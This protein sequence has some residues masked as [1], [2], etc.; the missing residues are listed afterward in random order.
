MLNARRLLLHCI[1]IGRKIVLPEVL[2]KV[3]VAYCHITEEEYWPNYQRCQEIWHSTVD[4][5]IK[6]G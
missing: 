2:Q 1:L 6:V 4:L 5:K 3:L